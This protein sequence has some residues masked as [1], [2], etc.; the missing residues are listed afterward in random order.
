MNPPIWNVFLLAWKWVLI[1]LI[2]GVL[3]IILFYVRREMAQKATTRR[4]SPVLATGRLQVVQPG[5]AAR[6]YPGTI[7]NLHADNRVGAEGDNDIV[8]DG[9]FISGHHAR[10]R[11]DGATWWVEDLDSRNGTFVAGKPCLSRT[12]QTLPPGVPLQLGDV[13]FELM[14]AE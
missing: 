3:I 10:I 1:L 12:P 2:Y 9:A 14:E 7:L 13:V 4:P 6:L 5:T 11:W 8:L